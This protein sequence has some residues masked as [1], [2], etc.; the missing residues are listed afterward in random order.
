MTQVSKLILVNCISR[1]MTA[2]NIAF[3]RLL[4]PHIK[5]NYQSQEE[6]SFKSMF[7]NNEYS[8][9]SYVLY[10]NRMWKD[11]E[12]LQYE[13]VEKEEEEARDK[14]SINTNQYGISCYLQSHIQSKGCKENMRRL[15]SCSSKSWMCVKGFWGQNIQIS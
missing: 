2:E 6:N 12:Y 5:A 14:A 3:N 13:I 9:F 7:N 11:A 1:E 4:A 8:E 10:K 15:G